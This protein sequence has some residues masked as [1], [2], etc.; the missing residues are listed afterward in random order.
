MAIVARARP[1]EPDFVLQMSRSWA[2][3]T[4]LGGTSGQP[5]LSVVDQS[6]DELV[7]RVRG[8]PNREQST[9][10]A[11]AILDDL[12]YDGTDVASS[13]LVALTIEVWRTRYAPDTLRPEQTRISIERS[14]LDD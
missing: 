9:A 5:D 6:L 10:L 2:Y 11:D 8:L 13:D 7:Q 3:L 1:V 4:N 12:G 14:R